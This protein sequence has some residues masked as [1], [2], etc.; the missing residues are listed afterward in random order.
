MGF[1]YVG[2][3]G[4]YFSAKIE[5]RTLINGTK[6]IRA[7]KQRCSLLCSR[8]KSSR[9]RPFV[10]SESSQSIIG[11]SEGNARRYQFVIGRRSCEII[12]LLHRIYEL[13]CP[14]QLISGNVRS[15]R[16]LVE[17]VIQHT[18]FS[19]T[20]HRTQQV[21]NGALKAAVS[22]STTLPSGLV[23]KQ[24]ETRGKPCDLG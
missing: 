22:I 9:C 8:A 24:C 1:R 12:S 23:D 20:L 21:Q 13:N 14:R 15:I 7:N 18:R 10:V 17:S 11:F 4:Y 19:W 16:L 6:S 2:A 5:T 3:D